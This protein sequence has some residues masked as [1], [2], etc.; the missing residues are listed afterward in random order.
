MLA[1]VEEQEA[2]GAVSI[3]GLL[4]LAP[5]T[6]QCCMLITQTPSNRYAYTHHMSIGGSFLGNMHSRPAAVHFACSF[7]I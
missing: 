5:L 4:G 1:C 6:Q 7:C 2:A 3:F